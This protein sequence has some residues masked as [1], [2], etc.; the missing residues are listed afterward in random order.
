MNR[1]RLGSKPP[2]SHSLKYSAYNLRMTHLKM[3]HPV[4]RLWINASQEQL[5][6][7]NSSGIY[8]NWMNCSLAD[9]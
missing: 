4:D 9:P 2:Q 5:D 7:E 6:I 8:T 3:G 1:S